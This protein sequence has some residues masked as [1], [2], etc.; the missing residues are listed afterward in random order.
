MLESGTVDLCLESVR[1]VILM[2]EEK[3]ILANHLYILF[4]ARKLCNVDMQ[5]TDK[6]SKWAKLHF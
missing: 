6:A 3:E 1:S 4:K 5:S 2:P